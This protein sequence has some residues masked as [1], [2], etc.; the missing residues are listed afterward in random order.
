MQENT[1]RNRNLTYYQG[2]LTLPIP[3]IKYRD[4]TLFFSNTFLTGKIFNGY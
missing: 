2:L 3:S 4:I 1:Q